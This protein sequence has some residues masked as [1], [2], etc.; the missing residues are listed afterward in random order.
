MS[1]D[2][3]DLLLAKD[4][5]SKIA[6][7]SFLILQVLYFWLLLDHLMYYHFLEIHRCFSLFH[8]LN[9]N[10]INLIFGQ[11]YLISEKVKYNSHFHQKNYY[12]TKLNF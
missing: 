10:L 7:S 2:F 3:S 5:P 11:T 8:L 1:R 12:L 6:E 9:G 4:S